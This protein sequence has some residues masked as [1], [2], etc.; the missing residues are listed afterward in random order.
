MS[1]QI[2]IIYSILII[3]IIKNVL[4]IQLKYL[5]MNANVHI[6]I[7]KNQIHINAYLPLKIVPLHTHIMTM[8]Q[9]N[10]IIIVL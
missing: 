3:I 5:Q 7:I 8:K 6:N 10:A 9:V 2:L 4:I 1:Q